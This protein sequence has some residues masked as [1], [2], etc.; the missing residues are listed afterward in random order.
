[1]TESDTKLG[2]RI[3]PRPSTVLGM[4]VLLAVAGFVAAC[5]SGTLR[6]VGGGGGASGA[7][8][9]TGGAAGAA[10]TTGAAGSGTD[11]DGGFG[12]PVCPD[13]AGHGGGCTPTDIQFCYK[14]CGVQKLGVKSVACFIYPGADAGMYSEMSGCCYDPSKDYSCYKVPTTANTACP[15]GVTPQGSMPCDVPTCTVCNSTGG[16]VGGMYLDSTVAAK[17]GYC[18]CQPPNASGARTWS[19]AS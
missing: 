13:N 16:I 7:G 5:G 2:V 11:V 19:C 10:G 8:G 12:Q 17:T 14:V 6:P 3:R 1:M 9:G 4:L 15:A 18:V